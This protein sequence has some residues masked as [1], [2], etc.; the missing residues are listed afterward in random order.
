VEDAPGGGCVIKI[1]I[2]FRTYA[3]EVPIRD[4]HSSVA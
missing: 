4:A 3:E 1:H 2:P